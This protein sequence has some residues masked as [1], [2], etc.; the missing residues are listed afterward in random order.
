[1]GLAKYGRTTALLAMFC[2]V[3]N[4]WAW[5]PL[6][7]DD[8]DPLDPGV[9]E[10][11]A[12]VAYYRGGDYTHWDFPFGLTYGVARDLD[13]HISFGG[14]RDEQSESFS[15][16]MRESGISDLELGAKWH[17][18][19]TDPL[20]I[21]NSIAPGVKLP[22]ASEQRRLGSGAADYDLIWIASRAF[23]DRIDIHLNLGY[24]WVGEADDVVHYG[25]AAYYQLTDSLQWVGEVFAEKEISSGTETVAAVNSGIRYYL[26]DQLILDCAAGT[27]LCGEAPDF[28]MT[29]GLT[30]DFG[31]DG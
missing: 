12:G 29:T 15:G 16:T 21:R 28:S 13:A 20:G 23:G 4:T 14:Q 17:F 1:M 2:W 18:I 5:R 7:V 8:A 3:N 26:T 9:F 25:L 30:W 22:T 24:A 11:D 27:K 31:F 19:A 6:T 10:L